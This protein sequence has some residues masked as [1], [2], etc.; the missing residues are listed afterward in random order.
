[1]SR[2]IAGTPQQIDGTRNV[3]GPKIRSGRF[4]DVLREDLSDMSLVDVPMAHSIQAAMTVRKTLEAPIGWRWKWKPFLA[5]HAGKGRGSRRFRNLVSAVSVA[6]AMTRRA[7]MPAGQSATAK[8][9]AA[10][11][12]AIRAPTRLAVVAKIG[13][14]LRGMKGTIKAMRMETK[15]EMSKPP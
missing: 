8:M 2:S 12:T 5:L 7:A 10:G 1:M 13:R 4:G 11:L 6:T 15:D 9:S 14:L 3:N